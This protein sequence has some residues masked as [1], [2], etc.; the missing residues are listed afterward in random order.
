VNNPPVLG[1]EDPPTRPA[2]VMWKDGTVVGQGI[3]G[4]VFDP[5]SQ[6]AYEAEQARKQELRQHANVAVLDD[7]RGK[8]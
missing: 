2:T 7:Y 6:L 1:F 8:N 3:L 4:S 5:E